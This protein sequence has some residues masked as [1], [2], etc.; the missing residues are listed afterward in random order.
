MLL[1]LQLQN[2]HVAVL[3][4]VLLA[5]RTADL[6]LSM[7]N[8]CLEFRTSHHHSQNDKYH[9]GEE[10]GNTS[11]CPRARPVQF[12]CTRAQDS[13][14]SGTACEDSEPY[15]CECHSNSR[16]HFALVLGEC[17]DHDGWKSD[18]DA[19]EESEEQRFHDHSSCI[20]NCEQTKQD[21]THNGRSCLMSASSTRYLESYVGQVPRTHLVR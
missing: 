12:G 4:R 3:T 10:C 8:L 18:E 11:I 15:H 7:L 9:A 16:A 2:V 21:D 6:F 19:A 13:A 20:A 17:D 14:T 1:R 5:P